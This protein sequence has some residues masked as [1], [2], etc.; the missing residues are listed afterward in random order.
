MHRPRRLALPP[1]LVLAVS[2][3]VAHAVSATQ[4]RAP[5]T[6]SHSQVIGGVDGDDQEN[7]DQI[8]VSLAGSSNGWAVAAWNPGP[9][10]RVAIAPPG[11]PFGRSATPVAVTLPESAPLVAVDDRGDV[12]VAWTSDDGEY[13]SPPDK[14]FQQYGCCERLQVA[15]LDA[16]GRVLSDQ[17]VTPAATTAQVASL[18]IARDG[19]T[20]AVGY[21]LS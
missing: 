13:L 10:L 17:V 4:S 16:A 7:D 6:W 12:A 20:V 19:A 3:G 2:L 14:Y 11:R 18:A 1:L 21:G 8:G 9:G 5:L 15:M